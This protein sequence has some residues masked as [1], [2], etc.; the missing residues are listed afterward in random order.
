MLEDLLGRSEL[1]DSKK[2]LVTMIEDLFVRSQ[3]FQELDDEQSYFCP[4]EAIGMV[5]QEIRHAQF[6][7]YTL[8][9]NRPHGFNDLYLR[10]FLQI[11][12][13]DAYNQLSEI[14]NLRPIDIHLL[15]FDEARIL[16]EKD[17]IDLRIIIPP[18][19]KRSQP[20]IVLAFELKI[21]SKESAEQLRKYN[22]FLAKN[23][24][25]ANII[26]FYLT[27]KGDDPHELNKTTWVAVSL[28]RVI[29]RFEN[30]CQ[31]EVGSDDARSLVRAYTKMMRRKHVPNEKSRER[32]LAQILWAKHKEA[33]DF[34]IDQ[35]PNAVR[36]FLDHL[37]EGR[38][39]ISA[40]ISSE[41]FVIKV[42]ENRA[43]SGWLFLYVEQW[44][45]LESVKNA[46]DNGMLFGV[47]IGPL[48]PK[49]VHASWTIVSG[50]KGARDKVYNLLSENK[51]IKKTRGPRG[52]RWTTT[53]RKSFELKETTLA[54][55]RDGD[56]SEFLKELK[57]FID[58]SVAQLDDALQSA[59]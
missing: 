8:D 53:D 51:L 36:D 29:E 49:A 38:K 2:D 41:K 7:A 54:K 5:N 15:S 19:A 24:P 33:L 59:T 42:D 3:E 14:T 44:V 20:E 40:A 37:I 6:L 50:E 55:A 43:S 10:S 27:L 47:S 25:S 12:A 58:G 31:K 39:V 32:E 28:E 34:L 46:E 11:A 13:E 4:F 17:D 48:G 1:S 16:R 22:D 9:P 23:Y 35:R 57:S 52:E 45:E 26:R 18:D 21:K 30:L 56:F